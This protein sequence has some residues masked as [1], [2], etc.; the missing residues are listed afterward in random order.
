GQGKGAKGKGP[1]LNWPNGAPSSPSSWGR[2][3]LA[4]PAQMGATRRRH[5]AHSRHRSSERVDTAG[6]G[7]IAAGHAPSA[8]AA[9]THLAAHVALAPTIRHALPR[10]LGA[11]R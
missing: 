6:V 3:A 5:T 9:G 10:S 7:C 2:H 11:L 4:L 8:E 1:I